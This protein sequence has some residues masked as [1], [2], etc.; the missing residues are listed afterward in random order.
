VVGPGTGWVGTSQ[1][2]A[3]KKVRTE[4]QKINDQKCSKVSKW[5]AAAVENMVKI[6]KE[7]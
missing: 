2:I 1:G 5:K 3:V 4:A 7:M 6:D